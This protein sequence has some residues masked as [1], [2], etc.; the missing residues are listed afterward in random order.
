VFLT[1]ERPSVRFGLSVECEVRF[2]H[3]PMADRSV[4][5]LAGAIRAIDGRPGIDNLSDEVAFDVKT[6]DGAARGRPPGAAALPRR[7]TL[8][9]RLPGHG[10]RPP[11]PGGGRGRAPAARPG[12]AGVPIHAATSRPSGSTLTSRPGSGR[13]STPT[14][15]RCARGRRRRPRTSRW[16]TGCIG[17]MRPSASSAM[18]SGARSCSPACL[19]A[20]SVTSET[21]WW[22]PPSATVCV[23]PPA[24]SGQRRA[25]GTGGWDPGNQ[26][27]AGLGAMAEHTRGR[28]RSLRADRAVRSA[29]GQGAVHRAVLR[30]ASPASPGAAPGTGPRTTAAPVA[31]APARPVR[32]VPR[33]APGAAHIEEIHSVV[34]I[35]DDGAGWTCSSADGAGRAGSGTGGTRR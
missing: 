24:R 32:Q 31:P 22:T 18:R 21:P 20:S 25:V 9:H 35:A 34:W 15:S 1:N 12:W 26:V 6:P 7:P 10:R 13:S 2:A 14:P 28:P 19:C 16:P 30:S 27:A 3:Q 33:Q 4:P 23:R 11:P 29:S 5:R 17:P 8:R